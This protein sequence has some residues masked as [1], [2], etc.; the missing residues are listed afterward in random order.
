MSQKET[1]RKV[2]RYIRK[3]RFR[4]IL[5]LILAALTVALTLYVPILTGDAVDLIID[6]GLVDMPGILVILKKIGIVMIV[7]AVAQ[8]VM[9][10]CNNYITYHVVKDIRIL[11]DVS[12]PTWIPSQMA[13]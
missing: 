3:Y 2:L 1:I 9:N 10:T 12:L 7:T 6:K 4:V 11:S 13:C 5:S 8:W